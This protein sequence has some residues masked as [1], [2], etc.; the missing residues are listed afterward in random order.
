MLTALPVGI[1]IMDCTGKQYFINESFAEIFKIADRKKHIA[2]GLNLLDDPLISE[3][4]KQRTRN[5][6]EFEV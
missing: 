4:V 3:S 5:G 2:R 1:S 6:E